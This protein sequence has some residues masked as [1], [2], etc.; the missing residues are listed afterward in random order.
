M[1]VEGSVADWPRTVSPTPRPHRY[2]TSGLASQPPPRQADGAP[3]ASGRYGR[4]ADGETMP[5][6]RAADVQGI[7]EQPGVVVDA[8]RPAEQAPR[9]QVQHRGQV[10][11]VHPR[12]AHT[13][14]MTARCLAGLKLSSSSLVE[15]HPMLRGE[16]SRFDSL[17]PLMEYRGMQAT[18]IFRRAFWGS[19]PPTLGA[20]QA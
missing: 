9:G 14:E 2:Q 18:V 6:A 1:S 3:R 10:Q 11:P 7:A 20:V 5:S 19:A 16:T 17:A 8:H 12:G 15:R 13:D 4:P